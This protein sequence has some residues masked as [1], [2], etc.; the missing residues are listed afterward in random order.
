M[1]E[2]LLLMTFPGRQAPG[3]NPI[4]IHEATDIRRWLVSLQTEALQALGRTQDAAAITLDRFDHIR[5]VRAAERRVPSS[6]ATTS[7]TRLDV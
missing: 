3:G 1:D 4:P 5:S 6:P 2:D 7:R